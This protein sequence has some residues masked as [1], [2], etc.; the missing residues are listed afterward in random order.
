MSGGASRA[1][2]FDLDGTLVDSA[3]DLQAAL[4]R[5]LA[6]EELPAL[7]LPAVKT[8]IGHGISH[9]V[10]RGYAAVGAPKAGAELAARAERLATLY[11][12]DLT[13]LTRPFAGVPETLAG[14]SRAGW[15]LGV[16][17]NKPTA[18]ARRLLAALSLD[19]MLAA[20]VGGDMTPYAKPHPEPLRLAL[21]Q[22]GVA[23]SV[24]AYVGDSAVDV[25]TGRAAGLPV[26]LVRHGYAQAPIESLGAD[27]VLESMPQLPDALRILVP[28]SA[29]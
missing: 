16:C 1:V 22:L 18:L 19:G 28:A 8:M 9:L 21:R 15:R 11:A 29:A 23:P 6:E 24:A 7:T 27:M 14:L 10:A 25:E 2:V 13:T 4:N 26:A 20:V 5:L 17:T 12:A 3:P